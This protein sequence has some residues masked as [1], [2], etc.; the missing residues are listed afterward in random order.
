MLYMGYY[1]Y[2]MGM[3]WDPTYMLVIIGMLLCV[4]ASAL[5]NSTMSK[6]SKV[7]N[8]NGLTGAGCLLKRAAGRPL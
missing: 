2:G 5:V 7:R 1:G 4:G 3:F 6:Y 8:M